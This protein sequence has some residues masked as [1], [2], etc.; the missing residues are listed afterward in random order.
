[1]LVSDPWVEGEDDPDA[2]FIAKMVAA[3]GPAWP[4]EL[5]KDLRFDPEAE[6][7]EIP[8]FDSEEVIVVR[9]V[10]LRLPFPVDRKFERVGRRTGHTPSELASA[11]VVDRLDAEIGDEGHPGPVR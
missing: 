9:K 3:Y 1:M 5:T 4:S 10:F 6:P 11:W 2:E 8:D 7:V